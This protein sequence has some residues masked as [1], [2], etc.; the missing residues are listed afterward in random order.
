MEMFSVSFTQSI[1]GYEGARRVLSQ[2]LGQLA[3]WPIPCCN[4][5]A[6]NSIIDDNIVYLCHLRYINANETNV[7]LLK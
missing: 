1:I 6:N 3:G 7:L 4:A 5:W 2:A